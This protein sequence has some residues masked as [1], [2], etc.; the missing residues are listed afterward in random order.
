[1]ALLKM[2][3]PK[4]RKNKKVHFLDTELWQPYKTVNKTSHLKFMQSVAWDGNNMLVLSQILIIV[5]KYLTFVHPLQGH[6]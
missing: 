1:M 4:F 2:F 6:A 3:F 5:P